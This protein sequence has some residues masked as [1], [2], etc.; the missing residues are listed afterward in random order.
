MARVL[1]MGVA[2]MTSTSGFSPFFFKEP[3]LDHAEFMLLID[4]GKPQPLKLDR[5]LDH[6]MGPDHELDFSSSNSFIKFLSL[7]PFYVL[8]SRATS[9]PTAPPIDGG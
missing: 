3:S 9:T 8:V 4:D 1:G 6:G 2:V 7:R 5:L